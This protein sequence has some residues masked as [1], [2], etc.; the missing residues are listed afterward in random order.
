MKIKN[1][2]HNGTVYQ[3]RP[4]AYGK[5]NFGGKEGFRILDTV[6]RI[7]AFQVWPINLTNKK[8]L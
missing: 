8:S 5:A 3:F 7:H 6:T 4:G 2:V 1:L